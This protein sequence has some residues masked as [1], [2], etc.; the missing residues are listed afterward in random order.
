MTTASKAEKDLKTAQQA[1]AE[2]KAKAQAEM[3]AAKKAEAEAK[4]EE[5]KGKVAVVAKSKL[6]DPH[7]KTHFP[8]EVPVV[9]PEMTDWIKCQIEAGL[10]EK[11]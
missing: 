3:E 10:M 9:V 8:A 7:A 6:Y 4:A 2:A 1:E 5:T 11:V